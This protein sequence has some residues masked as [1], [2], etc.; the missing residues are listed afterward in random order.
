MGKELSQF[1]IYTHL[2]GSGKK[3]PK[4]GYGNF[5]FQLSNL[6][7]LVFVLKNPTHWG[8]ETTVSTISAKPVLD[9]FEVCSL[10]TRINLSYTQQSYL[11]PKNQN[12]LLG[13]ADLGFFFNYRLRSTIKITI[14]STYVIDFSSCYS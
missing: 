7:Q 3:K 14:F 12:Y 1:F 11:C 9:I 2:G 13:K 10:V 5:F 4:Q 6:S 8:L